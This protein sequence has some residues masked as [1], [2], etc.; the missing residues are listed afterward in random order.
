M[1][2]RVRVELGERSYDVV[3]GRGASRE[4]ASL[5]PPDALRVAL[6]TQD[7]IPVDVST[8]VP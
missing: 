5:I 4:L 2:R 1:M 7:G 8:H 6:V 3:V